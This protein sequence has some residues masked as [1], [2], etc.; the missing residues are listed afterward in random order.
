VR[1]SGGYIP[2]EP[3]TQERVEQVLAEAH[4]SLDEPG[5]IAYAELSRR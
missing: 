2:Y 3:R 5:D 4:S 1:R